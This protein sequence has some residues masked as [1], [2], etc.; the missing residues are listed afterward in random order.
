M[1]LV[2][3]LEM[4]RQEMFQTKA[5]IL[6]AG[7][8]RLF[9]NNIIPDK[10]TL[11]AALIQADFSGYAPIALALADWS[12][13]ITNASNQAECDLATK[14]FT[15]SAAT[16]SNPIYGWYITH[17]SWGL[18]LSGRDPTAPF[19]MNAAGRVYSVAVKYIF[20]QMAGP[21]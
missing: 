18:I 5:Q 15:Q 1:E 6:A 17:T 11:S 20:D 16:V 19:Q 8:L 3:S 9:K 2:T 7:T 4:L 21:V 13:I 14:T 10:L 12:A